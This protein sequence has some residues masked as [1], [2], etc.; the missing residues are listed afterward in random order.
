MDYLPLFHNLNDRH[1][2]VIGGGEIALRKVRLVAES[3][4]KI[5]LVAKD[6]CSDLLEMDATDKQKGTN[7]LELKEIL[8]FG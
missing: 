8:S 5:T 7:K 4:A 2:L 6:F 3:G 1:V